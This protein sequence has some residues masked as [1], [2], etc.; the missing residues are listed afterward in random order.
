LNEA[1]DGPRK[2][3]IGPWDHFQPDRSI[4]GPRIDH[5]H[6][7]VRWL[8]YW[9]K[10]AANGVMDEPPIVIYMQRHQTPLVD[11]LEIEGE[12][13]AETHWPTEGAGNPAVLHL[14]AMCELTE[15]AGESGRNELEY[16]PTVGLSA[17]L[18]SY[19]FPGGLAGDQRAD[20]AFSLVYSTPP[21]DADTAIIGRPRAILYIDSTAPV[22]G[23][24]ITLS[25]VGPDGSSCLVSKGMLNATRRDSL[26]EPTPI[27]P[28]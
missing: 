16:V 17:G 3:L 27:T 18:Y 6:E 21:L 5:V 1:L 22:I 20:E 2:V 9:C 19:G 10:G 23:F 11:R 25:E 28:G 12:W 8:D 26:R 15:D 24:C 13:R 14:G 7:I 4:L